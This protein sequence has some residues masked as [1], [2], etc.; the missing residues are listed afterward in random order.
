MPGD[1]G[2]GVA[3]SGVPKRLVLVATG[4]VSGGMMGSPSQPIEDPSQSWN[5]LTVG[6]FTRKEQPPTPP[7]ALGPVVPAN[8]REPVQP[9]LA[10]TAPTT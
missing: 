3:A 2:D 5:A 4:N 1:G 8:H 7:P 9:R 10:N 6:G